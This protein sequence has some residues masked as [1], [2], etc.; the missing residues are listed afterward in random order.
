MTTLTNTYTLDIRVTRTMRVVAFA[1]TAVMGL[2]ALST[3]A[4][5]AGFIALAFI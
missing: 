2:A 5:I 3:V 4:L 1:M